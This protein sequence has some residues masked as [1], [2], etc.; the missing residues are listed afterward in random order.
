VLAFDLSFTGLPINAIHA[1]SGDLR[2]AADVERIV[3]SS[4]ADGCIHLGAASFVPTGQSNPEFV[5]AVNVLGT[6]YLLEAFRNHSRRARVLVIGSAHVYGATPEGVVIT[7]NAPMLPTSVYAISK[8]A[9]D[10]ASL[11]Y[12]KQ[13]GMYIMTARPNNHTGP[14]QSP[15][16]L[17]PSLGTQ[18]RAI[19]R[20]ESLNVLQVGNLD[21]RRDFTDVRDVVRAYRLLLERGLP[22]EAYNISSGSFLSIRQILETFCRIAGVSPNIQVD[23][24]RYRP[25]DAS[26]QLDISKL[27]EHTGWRPEIPFERTLED[28][29]AVI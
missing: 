24:E 2:N 7:E 1:F 10:M 20:G 23:P 8:A 18:I 9:A 11:A 5:M 26:P 16:F 19:A 29:L 3:A 27:R 25:F 15:P 13:H 21:S 22:G 14:G 17:V 4:E 12:S 6:L 28:L